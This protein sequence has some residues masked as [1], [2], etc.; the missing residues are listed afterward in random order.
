MTKSHYSIGID[1]GSESGRVLIINI[2]TGEI[3]GMHVIP[4]KHGVITESL[5]DN[6]RRIPIGSALQ[7]P[8]DY[9][10][11][12]EVGIPCAMA[13]A[14]IHSNQIIGLGVDFTSSTILPVDYDL[15]PLCFHKDWKY[16]HH[17]W[18]KLWKHHRTKVQ[19]DKIYKAAT[20]RKEIWLRKLGFNISEEWAIPKIYEVFEDARDVYEASAYFLEAADWIVSTL[21]STLIRNNCSLGFKAFWNE[22]DG[23]PEEFFNELDAEFGSTLLSKLHGNITMVYSM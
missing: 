21:T 16:Y 22:R 11:V 18:P 10:E 17:A 20:K 13:K 5:P 19:T 8:Q 3:K 4:Y 15:T 7:H 1:Y 9:L 23:F 14:G 6:P 2:K 12:L